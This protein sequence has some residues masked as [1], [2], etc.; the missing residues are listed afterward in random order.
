[1]GR[2]YASKWRKYKVLKSSA[3][4]AGTV[5]ETRPLSS[6]SLN[7]LLEKYG[8]VILKPIDGSGGSGVMQ[9]T[10]L[11][12][13]KYKVHFGKTSKKLAGKRAVSAYL[14]RKRQ[15]RS[16]IVQKRINLATL[17]GR[18]LDFR[19]MVQRRKSWKVTG[20]L[21]KIAGK[22]YIITNVARSKGYVLPAG[23]ALKRALSL[24]SRA[25]KPIE[26]RLEAVALR[27]AKRL[28][29]RFSWIRTVGLDMGVDKDGKVWIIEANFKPNIF[30]FRKLKDK[31][32]Y[33]RIA[34]YKKGK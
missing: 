34:A 11:G 5:P 9:V 18:P 8:S 10:S 7:L 16:Y 33:Y 4:L 3:S 27:A 32:M 6:K 15:K 29:S 31:S 14:R 12:K 23:T 28:N 30:L 19:V 2:T 26:S 17:H 22:G 13:Q 20:K 25:A 24:K 21:A 1:M